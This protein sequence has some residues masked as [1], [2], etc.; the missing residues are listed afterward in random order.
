MNSLTQ[1]IRGIGSSQFNKDFYSL[2]R[3]MLQIEKCSVFQ[4]SEDSEPHCLLAEAEDTQTRQLIR[5]LAYE[6]SQEGYLKDS[7][8]RRATTTTNNGVNI[9]CV[10]PAAISDGAYRRHFYEDAHI[11]DELAMTVLHRGQGLYFCFFRGEHQSKFTRQ[12]ASQLKSVSSFLAEVLNKHL[13]VMGA[14]QISDQESIFSQAGP[15]YRQKQYRGILDTLLSVPGGLS[16]REAE[17]CSAVALGYTSQGIS[18]HLGIS[19][20]TVGT[21]RKRAYTKLGISSQAELF[22]KILKWHAQVSSNPICLA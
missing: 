8:L 21:H 13:E 10:S 2:S 18:L 3:D 22:A 4:L 16:R 5:R 7:T 15:E 11:Q 9:S 6:F 14:R 19:I 12:D 1:L 17:I 20:N